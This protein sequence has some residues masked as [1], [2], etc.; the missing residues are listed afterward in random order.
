MAASRAVPRRRQPRQARSRS[1]VDTILVA[2]ARVFRRDGWRATTNRIAA[3]AGVGVGSVY[4]YFPNKQALLLA[5]AEKHLDVAEHALTPVL[6]EA[7]PLRDWLAAVQG[8]VLASQQFPSQALELVSG[9]ARG[10]LAARASQ[11]RE[12]VLAALQKQLE[13]RGHPALS[14]RCRA[15]AAFGAIGEL[16]VLAWLRNPPLPAAPQQ[17]VPQQPVPQQ[18]VAPP[19]AAELLQMAIRHCEAPPDDHERRVDDASLRPA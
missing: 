19:L 11:L 8:A 17:P 12:R 3:E 13:Q 14:A 6:N 1:T 4:E 18:P 16:T 10:Q 5:L 2:A 9:S 7:R 15:E